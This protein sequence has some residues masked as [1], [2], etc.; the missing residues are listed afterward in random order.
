MKSKISPCLWFDGQAETAARFYTG[1]FKNSRLGAIARY[2]PA[3]QEIHGQAP[4]SVMTVEF[5]LDGQTFTALNGGPAFKINEAISLQVERDTQ[6]ELDYYWEHLS[7]GGDPA[8]QRCGWLKDQF[9]V[10]WQIVPRILAELISDPDP[11]K[12]QRL[13]QALLQ[14]QKLE[15]ATL[16]QASRGD[17]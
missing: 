1:I 10:S 16:V 4:G 14:M 5:E 7:A 17:S 13:F 2:L 9:G 12:A 6:E 8:A 15:I 3:G 11:R